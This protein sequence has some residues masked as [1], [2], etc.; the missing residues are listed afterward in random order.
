MRYVYCMVEIAARSA[1]E[2]QK[3]ARLLADEIRPRQDGAVVIALEGELGAGKT[4]FAQGLARALGVKE[5]VLSPTFVLMKIYDLNQESGIRNYGFKYFIH[6]DC[7]RIQSPKDL[8]HLGLK[9]ILQDR[10]A[11][12]LIEWADRIKKI[13]PRDV[14]RLMFA[15]GVKHNERR[16]VM[17]EDI[18]EHIAVV[19]LTLKRAS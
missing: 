19:G 4:T 9:D 10:D 14:I 5:N 8:I 13:L 12:V 6:I 16:I 2:T 15:H 11:I 3:I 18:E 17:S 1:V 7:Y